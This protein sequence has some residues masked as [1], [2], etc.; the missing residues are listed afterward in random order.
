M[1]FRSILPARQFKQGPRSRKKKNE[2]NTATCPRCTPCSPS[3]TSPTCPSSSCAQVL[4][5][6]CDVREASRRQGHSAS[7]A[8]ERSETVTLLSR[9]EEQGT[10]KGL[11]RAHGGQAYILRPFVAYR[12]YSMLR[13]PNTPAPKKKEVVGNVEMKFNARL[14]SGNHR[15]RLPATWWLVATR[16]RQSFV[17]S[18]AEITIQQWIA[19]TSPAYIT[20]KPAPGY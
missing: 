18:R 8:L 1:L 19:S 20:R 6:P 11:Q 13:L 7:V 10:R 17:P 16:R 15:R 14:A 12:H 9:Y 5:E 4:F 3:L 2:F